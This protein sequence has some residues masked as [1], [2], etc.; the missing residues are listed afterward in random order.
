MAFN[1]TKLGGV[2]KK[3]GGGARGGGRPAAVA[4]AF[5]RARDEEDE[6]LATESQARI[7]SHA[8]TISRP[9]AVYFAWRK[10]NH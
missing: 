10:E 5:L 6:E 3:R 2:Q 9:P 7:N 4:A 8:R 1:L